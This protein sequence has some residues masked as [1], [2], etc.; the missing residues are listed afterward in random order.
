MEPNTEAPSVSQFIRSYPFRLL[1]FAGLTAVLFQLI[2]LAIESQGPT[3]MAVENGPM[4]AIQILLAGI[5]ELV[6]GSA[7][8]RSA[9][10]RGRPC[11]A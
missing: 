6:F 3:I 7:F 5:A 10:G 4:E 2:Y 1:L 11:A 8:R 9:R